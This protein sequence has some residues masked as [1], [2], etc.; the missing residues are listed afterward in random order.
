MSRPQ[1]RKKLLRLLEQQR[2]LIEQIAAS[3]SMLRGSF[4]RVHT[5]C[6]KPSC[7]CAQSARGHPHTRITWSER[8]RMLTRKVPP[9]QVQKVLEWTANYRRYRSLRRELRALQARIRDAADDLGQS[10]CE[11]TAN[12]LDYLRPRANMRTTPSSN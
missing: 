9:N 7:W 10:I 5:R 11:H 4:T 1:R 12:R 3:P 8:G 6:G 2:A